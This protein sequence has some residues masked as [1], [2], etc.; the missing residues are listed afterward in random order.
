VN[1]VA[2]ST[3]PRR[4]RSSSKPRTTTSQRIQML[5]RC[6]REWAD[7]MKTVFVESLDILYV[8]TPL[9]LLS[10]LMARETVLVL[11]VTSRRAH[12]P[13][14]NDTTGVDE[15]HE[16]HAGWFRRTIWASY[17]DNLVF[18]QK[19]SRRALFLL[20]G[21]WSIVTQ[22]F[23]PEIAS[24]HRGNSVPSRPFPKP[25]SDELLTCPVFPSTNSAKERN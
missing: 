14:N 20:L 16:F 25:S 4:R 8:L 22:H 17:S 6:C 2:S 3:S 5:K 10:T 11:Q 21:Y 15:Q 23:H 12:R 9:V 24:L 7:V 1:K 18:I 13:P 19:G